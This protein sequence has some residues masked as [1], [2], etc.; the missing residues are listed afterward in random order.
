MKRKALVLIFALFII[1]V[2]IE[3]NLQAQLPDSTRIQQLQERVDSQQRAIKKLDR[4]M[5]EAKDDIE[6]RASTGLVLFLFGTFC[7]LW[8]Q[9]SGRNPWLWFFLGA[10]FNFITVIILLSK[11]SQDK[12]RRAS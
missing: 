10:I 6:D 5:D 12:K 3:N 8:A 1:V 7:A 9:N 11:N 4:R 2:I